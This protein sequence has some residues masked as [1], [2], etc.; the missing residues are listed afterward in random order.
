MVHKGLNRKTP[1]DVF[2]RHTAV[3][4]FIVN[5]GAYDWELLRSLQEPFSSHKFLGHLS[6]LAGKHQ[7]SGWKDPHNG[8]PC[9]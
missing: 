4:S 2:L 7:A 5:K 3:Y 6:I 1:I 8:C 9:A